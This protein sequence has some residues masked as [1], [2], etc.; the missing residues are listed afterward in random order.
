[1]AGV[2]A[3]TAP[4]RRRLAVEAGH[5]GARLPGDQLAGG[6]VPRPEPPLVVGVDAPAGDVAE[7]DG[8]GAEA[9]DVADVAD[10]LGQRAG[11][12]HAAAPGRS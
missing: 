3:T 8:R 2:A 9:A 10:H 6:E 4:G 5:D 11:L 7:I 12:A 1:M